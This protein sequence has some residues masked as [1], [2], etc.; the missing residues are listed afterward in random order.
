MTVIDADDGEAR[1]RSEVFDADAYALFLR[2]TRLP[3]L[4]I[5]YDWRTDSYTVTTSPRLLSLLNRL[6]GTGEPT[7]SRRSR[8]ERGLSCLPARDRGARPD[9]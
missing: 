9:R 5:A 8:R 4:H 6:P 7:G 3:E 2:C 1:T